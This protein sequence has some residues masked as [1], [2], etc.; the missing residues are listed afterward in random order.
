MLK[1]DIPPIEMHIVWQN[2]KTNLN[3]RLRRMTNDHLK[4]QQKQHHK[5]I[6][7]FEYNHSDQE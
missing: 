4:R 5:Y 7:H 2:V 6:H 1:F 3:N